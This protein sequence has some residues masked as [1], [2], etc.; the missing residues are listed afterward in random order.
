MT[1]NSKT[2]WPWLVVLVLG[3]AGALCWWYRWFANEPAYHGKTVTEWLD[4][5]PLFKGM[6]Q[7][8]DTHVRYRVRE[9]IRWYIE[10]PVRR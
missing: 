7:E 1:P 9:A 6:T 2:R 10:K 3:G 4:A 5:M 8:T